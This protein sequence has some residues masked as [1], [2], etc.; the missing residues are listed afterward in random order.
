MLL[1]ETIQ[2]VEDIDWP[3]LRKRAFAQ[4]SRKKKS[5]EDWDGRAED[6]AKRAQNT[7]YDSLLLDKLPLTPESTVLDIGCGPGTLALPI[8]KKV[9][10]VTALDFSKKMLELLQKKA[11]KQN[12][13]NIVTKHLAWEDDWYSSEIAPH[14]ITL[15][16]RST[17][18]ENLPMVLRKLDSFATKAVFLTDRISPTPF[19]PEA[20]AAVGLDFTPGPDYIY[21]LNILHSMGIAADVTILTLEDTKKHVSLKE[22]LL[23]FLWMFDTLTEQQTVQLQDYLHSISTKEPDGTYTITRSTPPR[24]AL[25]SWEKS[26]N[27]KNTL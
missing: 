13:A 16:S 12:L 1:P 22:A 17:G 26:N 25:I 15:A 21:T 7:S 24:W 20:F 11:Q 9:N 2:T 18:V 14:E 27:V 5:A 3:E 19:E 10:K 4:K 6:F 8:A 23:N